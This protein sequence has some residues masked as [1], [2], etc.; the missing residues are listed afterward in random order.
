VCSGERDEIQQGGKGKVNGDKIS[1]G[2]RER[3][4]ETM[5]SSLLAEFE[6]G[7]FSSDFIFIFNI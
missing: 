6:R 1:E 3:Q 7:T 5:S 2:E 4:R